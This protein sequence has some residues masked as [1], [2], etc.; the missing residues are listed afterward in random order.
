MLT[1]LY[2]GSFNPIHIGHQIIANAMLNHTPMDE[3]WFVVSP[4]NPFKVNQQLLDDRARVEMVRQAV[5]DHPQIQ[6]C[7]IELSLPKP[8]YTHNTLTHL[9][10]LHPHRE[11][12]LIMGSDN[13]EHLD[14]WRNIE[15]ILAHHQVYVFPRPDH[16]FGPWATHPSIHRVDCP[17]MDISSSHIRQE[18]AQGHS[19]RYLVSPPVLDLIN[20]NHYYQD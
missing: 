9:H 7:D 3:L 18:I 6:V 15:D 13:L 5:S 11:F 19:I 16:P 12:C 4:Q 14:R 17:M 8:S 1:G 2:F 20:R 10:Q